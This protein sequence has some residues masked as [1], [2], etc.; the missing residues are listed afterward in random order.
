MSNWYGM[1]A[2]D[3]SNQPSNPLPVVDPSAFK[4]FSYSLMVVIVHQL[5]HCLV[6]S[7]NSTS[8]YTYVYTCLHMLTL[9]S[10]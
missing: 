7:F 5:I 1:V 10:G 2:L 8:K 9:R 6:I 3:H 4:I